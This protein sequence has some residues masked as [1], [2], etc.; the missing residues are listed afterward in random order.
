MS[1]EI[2]PE[3]FDQY[4]P[5]APTALCVKECVRLAALRAHECKGP[6]LD[7]G[8]GD[9]L[10]AKLACEGEDVWGIDIDANEGRL[11]QATRAYSQIVL[12]DITRVWIPEQLF[13][14]CIANCSL[15]H[16]P[17]IHAALSNIHKALVPGGRAFLFVPNREWARHLL[18]VRVLDALGLSKGGDLIQ[19]GIDDLF[20]HHHLY[21]EDG[22]R[23]IVE[24]AG[25]EVL[26]VQPVGSTAST[27]AFEVFLLP[28]LLGLVNKK[29]TTRWT[30]FPNARK[31]MSRT[32]YRAV[33]AA[34]RLG[35]EQERTAEFLLVVRR[36]G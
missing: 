15:E 27:V 24:R 17:D 18:S 35:H 11:A 13:Q 14:T 2:T 21:D 28:S 8:C 10:F 30:N 34:L 1:D 7:V 19:K 32:V 22:W 3:D 29:L 23:E 33:R 12:A 9:G 5:Y 16:V 6:I 26:E 36:P 4:F 31:R 25:F 20:V